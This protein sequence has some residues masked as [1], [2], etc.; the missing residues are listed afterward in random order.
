[1]CTIRRAT[2]LLVPLVCLA[3]QLA[4]AQGDGIFVISDLPHTIAD[5][6]AQGHEVS[7]DLFEATY[8]VAESQA[9][10]SAE[11]ASLDDWLE[12]TKFEP[13]T[14]WT[15]CNWTCPGWQLDVDYLNWRL[16]HRGTD[17]AIPTNNAALA[18]GNGTVQH[19]EMQWQAGVRARLGYRTESG[20]QFGLGYT[21]YH[22]ADNAAANAPAGGNL[23]ATRSHPDFFE[24]AATA[25]ANG[26]FDLDILD[27]DARYPVVIDDVFG[28]ELFGGL[29]GAE[30]EQELS[31]AYNGVDFT[32]G[33]VDDQLSISAIG[34]RVGGEAHW[35]VSPSW[36]LFGNLAGSVLYG[37]FDRTLVETN[38]N[39]VDTVVNI[40]DSY[41]RPMSVIETALGVE[42]QF[43]RRVQVR[44]GY[45]LADW[46]GAVDRGMFTDN[47]HEGSFAPIS[48]NL[49]LHGL[50][51]RATFRR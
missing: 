42:W 48:D 27:L 36:S 38:Q 29:R 46:V 18:V 32:N 19:L 14:D 16:E 5:L 12:E 41:G 24:Q 8:E 25:T 44:V 2:L 31:I 37:R 40:R 15:Y 3:S 28:L 50:F 43:R 35:K 11:Y 30:M 21:Y 20:W 17:Y 6:Q 51:V 4:R 13:G 39:G 1:M 33:Q 22:A 9:A 10:L 47:T 7:H 45:E 34:A 23:W 26:S 49:L